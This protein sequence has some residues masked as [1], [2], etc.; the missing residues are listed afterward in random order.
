MISISACNFS[1]RLALFPARRSDVFANP[2][3]T[4]KRSENNYTLSVL[5]GK[6]GLSGFDLDHR[7][8]L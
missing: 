7:G 4:S 8:G 1:S 2:V 6:A 5:A 3:Y